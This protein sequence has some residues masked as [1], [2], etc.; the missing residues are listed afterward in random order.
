MS[1]DNIQSA[2]IGASGFVGGNLSGRFPFS[3]TFDS[4]T[5]ESSAGKTYDLLVSAAPSAVKWKANKF[6]E[7]DKKMVDEYLARLGR[8]NAQHCIGISTCDVYE[9]PR[10]VDEDTNIESTLETLHPYGKHRFQIEEFMRSHFERVTIIRLP[11]LFG[12]GLKKNVVFDFLHNN[13]L[14]NIHSEGIFQFYNLEHLWRDITIACEANI[15]LLNITSEPVRVVE[16]AEYCFGRTFHNSTK[17]KPAHYDIRS[18]H[19]HLFG[20]E[21][22]YLYSKRV[23][24]DELKQFVEREKTV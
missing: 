5:I 9:V 24:L 13:Q 7:E 12:K 6:P 10:D 23:V 19:A 8:I 16:I 20:G 1:K 15:P 21:Q 11:A 22:G 17:Q 14:E 4:K 3:E 18:K 2:L